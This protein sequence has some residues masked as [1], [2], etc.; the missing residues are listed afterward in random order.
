MKKANGR[1]EEIAERRRKE[2]EES[3][4]KEQELAA[5]SIQ[6]ALRKKKAQKVLAQRRAKHQAELLAAKNETERQALLER[7]AKEIAAIKMQSAF[8]C[9][10][11]R[12]EVE[13]RRA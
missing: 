3:A 12:K 2:A 9:T 4:R 13:G 6:S 1:R 8:R 5:I 7:Q 11:A 10:Q